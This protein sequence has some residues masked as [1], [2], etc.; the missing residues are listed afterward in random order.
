MEK[1]FV[2]PVKGSESSEG[3][4]ALEE[5]EAMGEL[6]RRRG[7]QGSV[8]PISSSVE[9]AAADNVYHGHGCGFHGVVLF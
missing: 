4:V 9:A 7:F 2:I 8:V 6:A 1:G 3:G 5:R